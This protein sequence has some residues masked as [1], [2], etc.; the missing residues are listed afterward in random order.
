LSGLTRPLRIPSKSSQ[1]VMNNHPT[2]DSA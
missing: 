2:F 1:F